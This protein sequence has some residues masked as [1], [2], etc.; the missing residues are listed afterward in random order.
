LAVTVPL[1]PAPAT[2]SVN[3]LGLDSGAPG[4]VQR[5]PVIEPA[6]ASEKAMVEVIDKDKTSR[7]LKDALLGGTKKIIVSTI[8]KFPL[9]L[10][11]L[12]QLGKLPGKS[13]A[14]IIDEAHSSQAG[15]DS[16]SG[17]GKKA[18]GQDDDDDEDKLEDGD[19]SAGQSAD[20]VQVNY[21]A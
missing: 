12:A 19:E 6:L 16:Y 1:A 11:D 14:V 18:G 17:S 15:D 20:G 4:L 13:Y 3:W 8:Q 10:E 2:V 9:I 5:T 21:F 7:D